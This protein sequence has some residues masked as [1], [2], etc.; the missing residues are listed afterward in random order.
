[1]TPRKVSTFRIDQE[2][3]D[4]MQVLWA[5]DGVLPAEQ[6]RR[7]L[8]AYLEA[9]G[10]MVKAGPAVRANAPKGRKPRQQR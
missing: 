3:L 2:L 4:G 7:A 8:R 5:R 9:R 1:M 10:V 6:M